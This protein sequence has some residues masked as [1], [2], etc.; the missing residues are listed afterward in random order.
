[1][2]RVLARKRRRLCELE[3][4]GRC[5]APR[6]QR[7]LD[8]GLGIRVHNQDVAT[9]RIGV[10]PNN[11]DLLPGEKTRLGELLSNVQSLV[12]RERISRLP[13]KKV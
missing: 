4:S 10:P 9:V 1:M 13:V 12:G 2:S 3:K 7:I 5:S 11:I 6:I 8:V